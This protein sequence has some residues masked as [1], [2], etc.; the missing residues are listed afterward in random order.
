M[1]QL[2]GSFHSQFTN[3]K[4]KFHLR[5]KAYSNKLKEMKA[6]MEL[7]FLLFLY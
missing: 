5:L 7:E 3:S 4:S 6:V 2:E 1:K